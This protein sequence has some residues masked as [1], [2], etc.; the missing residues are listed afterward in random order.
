MKTKFRLLFLPSLMTSR[1]PVVRDKVF[2]QR[3]T[4]GSAQG[5]A[6][7]FISVSQPKNFRAQPW[8]KWFTPLIKH[9][10]YRKGMAIRFCVT[11][12]RVNHTHPKKSALA[13]HKE[14]KLCTTLWQYLNINV[15]L[16]LTWICLQCWKGQNRHFSK[17]Q[18]YFFI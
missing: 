6:L 18:I 7:S 2:T 11:W 5:G 10:L 9:I 4:G 8:P 12:G 16:Y 14:L 17:K 3:H 15:M 13:G 1:V